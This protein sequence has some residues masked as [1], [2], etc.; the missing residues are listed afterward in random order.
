M[1]GGKGVLLI[2]QNG[3][4]DF[5]ACRTEPPITYGWL[6]AIA[7]MGKKGFVTV[8]KESWIYLGDGKEAPWRRAK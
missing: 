2:S 4:E 6:Y 8:G 5:V 1:I 3:G 7:P